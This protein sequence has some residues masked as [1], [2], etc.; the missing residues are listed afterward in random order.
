MRIITWNV[1]GIRSVLAKEK[2][3]TKHPKPI[4]NNTL[5]TLIDELQ[6]DVICLQE[7]KCDSA[8]ITNTV[9]TINQY[10]IYTNCATRKGYSGVA[11]FTKHPPINT[12]Y[13]FPGIPADNE[14]NNE[15]RVITCEFTN[16][17]VIGVYTPNSKPQLERLDYRVNTWEVTFRN[18]IITLQKKKPVIVCGD[19]NVAPTPLDLSNPTANKNSHGF[20]PEERQAFS[21]LINECQLTDSYRYIH[22]TTQKY[23]WFSP[24]LKSKDRSKGWRIDHLLVSNRLTKS[25]KAAEI[26]LDYYGSDH[27]PCS[28][29]LVS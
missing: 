11:I 27:V 25:I 4:P 16:Y 18:F 5:Q 8:Q 21:Q 9:S 10:Q 1:N 12:I 22:P 7:I 3:G 19:L 26:H 2:N 28:V 23:S 20:T 14:L 29:D 6:P 15:G 13:G 17:Y 24:F